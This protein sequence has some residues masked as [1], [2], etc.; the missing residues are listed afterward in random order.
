MRGWVSITISINK[1]MAK[2]LEQII[3][4]GWYGTRSDFIRI[5]V[6]EKILRDYPQLAPRDLEPPQPTE[7]T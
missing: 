1:G 4:A 5:A 3:E 7:I 6:R 2:I